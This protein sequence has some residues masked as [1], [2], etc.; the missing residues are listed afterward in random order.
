MT[1]GTGIC[2]CDMEGTPPAM[3]L[4]QMAGGHWQCPGMALIAGFP[5]A[6]IGCTL[7]VGHVRDGWEGCD[8]T[9]FAASEIDT[10]KPRSTGQIVVFSGVST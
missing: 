10:T 2:P 7:G 4:A 6:G 3:M 1:C 5:A 9:G 8:G